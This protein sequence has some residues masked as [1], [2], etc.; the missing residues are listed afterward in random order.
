MRL[1]ASK[2][3]LVLTLVLCFWGSSVP[4]SAQSWSN[5]YTHRRAI[6]IDHTKVPNTDQVNF[7]VLISGTYPYLASTANGGAVT[8]ANGYDILFTSDVNGTSP[9]AFERETYDPSTGTVNFWVNV[10]TVSHT[11]DTVIYLFYGNSSVTTDPSSAMATWDNN[12]AGVWHLPDGTT[13]SA[14]DSTLNSNTGTII[15]ATA[16]TGQIGGAAAFDGSTGLI[17][18]SNNSS[19]DVASGDFTASVWFYANSY[20]G[21]NTVFDKGT[22]SSNRDYSFWINSSSGGWW[23]IGSG[24]GEYWSGSGF[25]TGTWHYLVMQRS[26]STSRV[27]LDGSSAFSTT[28]FTG[29]TDSGG[30][31]DFSGNPTEGGSLWDGKLDE[32]RISNTARSADWITTEY[33]N[34]SNPAT[35]YSIIGAANSN[36]GTSGNPLITSA[37]LTANPSSLAFG[38]GYV[39]VSIALPV[40]L[41]NFGIANVNFSNVSIS[42]PGFNASGVLTGQILTPGQSATLNV[43]FVPPATGS[44]TGSVTLSSNATNAPTIISLSGTGTQASVSHSVTLSWSA[45]NSSVAGYNIYRSQV[46]GGPYAKQNSSLDAT[47]T[48]TDTA[49]Q[50]GQQYYYVATSVDS[51]NNESTDSNEVSVTIPTP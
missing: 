14:G 19:I 49:V 22:T 46:S 23:A 20:S 39:G 17:T 36:S 28:D 47:M 16:A 5:N 6:T 1:T 37:Y 45:S 25:T 41:T 40:T 43:T 27:F 26:G 34:Q 51:S 33:N 10:P 50:S 13:L 21:F 48:Y 9:L 30:N 29:T 38:N 24:G 32:F 8:S 11:S 35:F 7:P 2:S 3:V 4:A 31:L 44:V 18:V 12:Y 42:G 15:G